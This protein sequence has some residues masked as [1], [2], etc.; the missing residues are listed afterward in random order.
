M[1]YT[2][3]FKE[4]GELPGMAPAMP[5]MPGM[6]APVAPAPPPPPVHRGQYTNVVTALNLLKN[7]ILKGNLKSDVPTELVIRYVQNTGQAS[8]TY[9]DLIDANENEPGMKNIVKNI[10]PDTVTVA[11]DAGQSA[12]NAD[13]NAAQAAANPQQ[14]VSNMAKSAAQRRQKSLF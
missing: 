10:T 8:F 4:E 6:P 2:E 9:Q 14:T 1:R 11:T 7:Q 5:A 12:S 3:F 13:S